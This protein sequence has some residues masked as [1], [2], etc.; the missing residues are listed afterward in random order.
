MTPEQLEE[1]SATNEE[2]PDVITVVDRN[3]KDNSI[4]AEILDNINLNE[5]EN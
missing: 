5:T 1:A 4:N 2:N 3:G